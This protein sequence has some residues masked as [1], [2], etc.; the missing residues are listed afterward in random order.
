MLGARMETH[1]Y[2]SWTGLL[3]IES[4]IGLSYDQHRDSS[5]K[6]DFKSGEDFDPFAVVKFHEEP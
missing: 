1:I 3:A 4:Q 5:L 2:G 6:V